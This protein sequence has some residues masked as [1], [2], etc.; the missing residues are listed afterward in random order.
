MLGWMKHKLKSRLVAVLHGDRPGL[1]SGAGP[2]GGFRDN[3]RG[4]PR[5]KKGN[6]NKSLGRSSPGRRDS[7]CKGPGVRCV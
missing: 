5:M 4:H 1:G 2:P 3:K 6:P 7:K